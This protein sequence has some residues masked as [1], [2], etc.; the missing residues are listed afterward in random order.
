MQAVKQNFNF[1]FVS[2]LHIILTGCYCELFWFR[3]LKSVKLDLLIVTLVK[4]LP[5]G[6]VKSSKS[7]IVTPVFTWNEL[8]FQ[9]PDAGREFN[10]SSV[11]VTLIT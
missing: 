7:F 5:I 3:Y 10:C 2:V 4:L 1:S 6:A 11:A 9:I 8:F